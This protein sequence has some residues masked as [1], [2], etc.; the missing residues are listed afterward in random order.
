MIL[1]TGATGYVGG[2][3]VTALLQKGERVRC[4]A[5]NSSRLRRPGWEALEIVEGEALDVD[6]V[7]RAM[8]GVK[9]AYYLIHSMGAAGSD[10]AKRDIEIATLFASTAASQNIERLVYLG[11]LGDSTSKLSKHLHSRHATGDALRTGPVPVIEFRA[12]MV[13]G[14]GSLSFE[15][16]RDMVERLPVMVGPKWVR[17]KTQ[18]IAIRDVLAYLESAHD[19]RLSMNCVYEIGGTDVTSYQE[20][21][22]LYARL[23]GLRRFMIDVPLLTPRLSSYW[24]DFITA[25]PAS[26]SRPLIDGLRHETICHDKQALTDFPFKPIGVEEAM[27]LAIERDVNGDVET[28]WS[29][30]FSVLRQSLPPNLSTMQIE[31]MIIEHRFR[32]VN[33][34]AA[35]VFDAT[36]RI[37]G[38]Y[39][40][41]YADFLWELRG[42]LDRV[43][44]GVGMRRG[45]RSHSQLRVG[46]PVDFWRV[47][48]LVPNRLLRLHAEMK[49]PGKAWLQ[50]EVRE[51][52]ESSCTIE[53]TTFFEPKGVFGQLYWY[54]L[55]PLHKLIFSGMINQIVS[56]AQRSS[57]AMQ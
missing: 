38:D 10:F 27:R 53:Q 41:P 2:R 40:W 31:G 37:G 15:L 4:L 51:Q 7:S 45:R 50:W 32:T 24:V 33:L 23:R 57:E 35:Q 20:L 5:R 21:M 56:R 19:Q 25:V 42:H 36:T 16:L 22:D 14:S 49:V 3:L 47:D 17:T 43:V 30:S 52:N 48:E 55:F 11:G 9:T 1:V 46:D 8:E 39:G 54:S 6:A 26:V 34:P 28:R 13:V 29:D 44:G 18:P 12:G